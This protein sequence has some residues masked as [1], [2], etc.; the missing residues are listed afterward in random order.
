MKKIMLGRARA[1]NI[2]FELEQLNV[3]NPAVIVQKSSRCVRTVFRLLGKKTL[4]L[5]LGQD[6]PQD[7]DAVILICEKEF[8]YDSIDFDV[9]FFVIITGPQRDMD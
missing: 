9:P 7:V 5:E 3:T 2:P 1:H 8:D 4:R 6:L